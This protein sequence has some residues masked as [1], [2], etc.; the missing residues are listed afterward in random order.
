[1][2]DILG[3]SMDIH[4]LTPYVLNRMG[5]DY[6]MK[7]LWLE[8]IFYKELDRDLKHLE[9]MDLKDLILK[10]IIATLERRNLFIKE[11]MIG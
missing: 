11:K 6:R 9:D 7:E 5:Q 3:H 10:V 8:V 1:M 2:L 4:W